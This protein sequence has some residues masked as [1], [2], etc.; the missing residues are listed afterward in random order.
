MKRFALLS[1]AI[2]ILGAC[3]RGASGEASSGIEGR[4]TIGPTCP[5]ERPD[6]PC[7]DAPSVATVRVLSGSDV[8][9]TGTSAKDGTFRIAVPPGTY[10]VEADPASGSAIARGIPVNNV[11]VHEGEFTHVDVTVDS[12]IR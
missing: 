5:V 8:V 3:G 1:A 6:S 4:V 12:G 9:A 10:T 2:L 7:P 11:V